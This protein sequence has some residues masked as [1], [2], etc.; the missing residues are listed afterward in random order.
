M[1]TSGFTQDIIEAFRSSPV[2]LPLARQAIG[3]LEEEGYDA[4][5]TMKRGIIEALAP[6]MRGASPVVA[7]I[8]ARALHEHVDWY[9]VVIAVATDE[10]MN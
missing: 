5:E 7:Q 4:A 10:T 3:L 9:E 2:S 1:T 8:V 6:V